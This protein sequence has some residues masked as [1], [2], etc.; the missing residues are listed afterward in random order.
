MESARFLLEIQILIW[1]L[2]FSSGDMG[3]EKYFF[4]I[5]KTNLHWL[6]RPKSDGAEL[7]DYR[8]GGVRRG[9]GGDKPSRHERTMVA[10]LTTV[11]GD[12]P[13]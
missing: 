7:M 8:A 5:G 6:Q 11:R 12:P 2:L 10:Q 9:V 4:A 13:D 1:V 3:R